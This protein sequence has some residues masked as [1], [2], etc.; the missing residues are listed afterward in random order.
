MLDS[1]VVASWD[2]GHLFLSPAQVLFC[3][4]GTALV[5]GLNNDAEPGTALDFSSGAQGYG[6]GVWVCA[7]WC[8]DV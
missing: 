6:A 5:T 3:Q 4:E 1:A 8:I 7:G 2:T